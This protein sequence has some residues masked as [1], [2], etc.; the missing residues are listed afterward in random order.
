MCACVSV[1]VLQQ[2]KYKPKRS[3]TIQSDLSKVETACGR[4]RAMLQQVIEYVDNV[5]VSSPA[6]SGFGSFACTTFKV[7]EKL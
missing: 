5:L 3:V 1:E 6:T 7:L 4:L 2:G